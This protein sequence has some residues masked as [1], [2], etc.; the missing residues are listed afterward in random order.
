MLPARRR[1]VEAACERAERVAELEV[2]VEQLTEAVTSHAEV[3][4]AIGVVIA[5][6]GLRPAE[7]WDVL[8]EVS[9]RTNTR[10]RL[11]ARCL[12][13]WPRTRELDPVIRA[14]LERQLAQRQG[15]ASPVA[16]EPH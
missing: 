11:V 9:M 7:A 10:L 15:S 3:D 12:I 2:Q 5:V 14:E 4:Q 1:A 8:R 6:G 16:T 13:A